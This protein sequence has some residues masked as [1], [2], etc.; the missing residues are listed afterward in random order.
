M[1]CFRAVKQD[2]GDN[3]AQNHLAGV[4]CLRLLSRGKS[5]INRSDSSGVGFVGA[6]HRCIIGID[7][8]DKSGHKANACT[9]V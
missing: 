6:Y 1:A 8:T 4:L 3:L 9:L 5:F 7:P 2:K